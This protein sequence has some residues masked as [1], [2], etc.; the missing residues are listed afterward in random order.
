[1]PGAFASVKARPRLPSTALHRRPGIIVTPDATVRSDEDIT[2]IA[3][4]GRTV[5]ASLVARDPGTD[6]AVLRVHDTDLPLADL[7][8]PASLKVGH[9]VL[10]VGHGPRVS[11]GVVSTLGGR[12]RTWRGGEIDQLMRLDLTLYPGFSGGPLVDVKGRVVG[13]NTSGLSRQLELGIPVSPVTGDADEL[14]VTE[15]VD[16]GISGGGIEPD[17]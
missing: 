5:A 4:D 2:I 6:L 1:M 13:I 17:R 3:P 12:W 8:D 7:G 10:A 16:D 14:T 11:W 9:I 15:R